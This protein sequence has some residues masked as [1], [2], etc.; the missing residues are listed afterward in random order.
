MTFLPLTFD[1]STMTLEGRTDKQAT[2]SVATVW[3]G[4]SQKS[5]GVAQLVFRVQDVGSSHVIAIK[6]RSALLFLL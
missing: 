6:N 4:T 3:A 2:S 1:F 5:R